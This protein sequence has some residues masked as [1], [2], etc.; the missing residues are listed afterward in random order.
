M[1]KK[2]WIIIIAIVAVAII[3]LFI[4]KKKM[5]NSFLDGPGMVYTWTDYEL[6]GSWKEV[7]PPDYRKPAELSV[8]KNTIEFTCDGTTKKFKYNLSESISIYGKPEGEV[9]L[10]LENCDEFESLIFHEEKREDGSLFPVLSGT[11]FEYDGR[12]EIVIV[13]FVMNGMDNL[14]E[15]FE[16]TTAK[17]RNDIIPLPPTEPIKLDGAISAYRWP[18]YELYGEW[19]ETQKVDWRGPVELLIDRDTIEFRC[20][21]KTKTFKYKIPDYVEVLGIPEGEV[22]LELT[23]CDEFESLIFHEEGT[24]HTNMFPVLSGTLFEY[25]GRGEI[26]VAEFV[27]KDKTDLPEGFESES[28]KKRNYSEPVPMY[29]EK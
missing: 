9:Y 17:V 26:I 5:D 15:N 12:G 25:D 27:H 28:L 24:N 22:K 11:A 23:D 20:D 2:M 8:G 21:G 3:I 16:S 10:N 29:T 18:D 13:E 4:A 6:Q 7:N 19:A 1:K 14:P